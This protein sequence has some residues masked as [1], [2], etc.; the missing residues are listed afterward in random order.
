MNWRYINW[1]ELNVQ[2]WNLFYMDSKS[3]PL[4]SVHNQPIH[5]L[6]KK[7]KRESKPTAAEPQVLQALPSSLED[8]DG[9]IRAI[10]VVSELWGIT[11][12][13]AFIMLSVCSYKDPVWKDVP[14]WPRHL[15]PWAVAAYL[16]IYFQ[17]F[18]CLP[19]HKTEIRQ[20]SC[21]FQTF[22]TLVSG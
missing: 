1:I 22:Q 11:F 3:C 4:N 19:L 7:K 15:L 14:C 6:E 20:A 18:K 13:T 8:G 21:R 10:L 9:E 16:L 5:V 17:T 12:Q 2:Y